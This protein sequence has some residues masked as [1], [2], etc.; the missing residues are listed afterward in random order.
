M[1]CRI[2]CLRFLQNRDNSSVWVN[3]VLNLKLSIVPMWNWTEQ[4]LL[5][6][7]SVSDH[8]PD[9]FSPLKFYFE[10]W[11]GVLSMFLS[12]LSILFMFPCSKQ[13]SSSK[14]SFFFQQKW[15][16]IHSSIW[17]IKQILN[18]LDHSQKLFHVLSEFLSVVFN[19]NNFLEYW[20]LIELGLFDMFISQ[21]THLDSS[22]HL[23][24]SLHIKPRKCTS[25]FD[26]KLVHSFQQVNFSLLQSI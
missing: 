19:T 24:G 17:A 10:C 25:W 8:L 23:I 6:D 1:S 3:L 9:M 21:I 5:V 7:F 16:P 11:D 2:I 12:K 18:L 22:S 14:H 15:F 13:N 20:V 26:S 4:S